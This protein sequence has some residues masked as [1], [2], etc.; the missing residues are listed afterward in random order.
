[1]KFEEFAKVWETVRVLLKFK[2]EGV[3][4]SCLVEVED[5][6][7]RVR[8]DNVAEIEEVAIVFGTNAPQPTGFYYPNATFSFFRSNLFLR[9]N[10]EVLG[11]QRGNQSLLK[12]HVVTLRFTKFFFRDLFTQNKFENVNCKA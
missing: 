4:K 7:R 10:L 11:F 3:E 6:L 2:R 8:G 1:M 9:G 5:V 12:I